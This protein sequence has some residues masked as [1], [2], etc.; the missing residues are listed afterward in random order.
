MPTTPPIVY[1]VQPVPAPRTKQ[2]VHALITAGVLIDVGG[3]PADLVELP[4][5][6]P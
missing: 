5:L 3:D 2:E 4:D 6:R 1:A